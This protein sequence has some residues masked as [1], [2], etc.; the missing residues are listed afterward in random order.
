MW[1]AFDIPQWNSFGKKTITEKFYLP[2]SNG[3]FLL[4][5]GVFRSS[6]S[7]GE[8]KSWLG[9]PTVWNELQSSDVGVT[10]PGRKNESKPSIKSCDTE[11]VMSGGFTTGLVGA[12][13]FVLLG[14]PGQQKKSKNFSK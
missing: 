8:E 14:R 6:L 12:L 5:F 9:L 7:V 3:E 11:S 1:H 10:E 13:V 2:F 4:S